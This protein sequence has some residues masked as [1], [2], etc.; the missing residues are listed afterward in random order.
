MNIRSPSLEE[1]FEVL[2]QEQ[3]EIGKAV[4][5]YPISLLQRRFRL[6]YTP[7]VELMNELKKKGLVLAVNESAVQLNNE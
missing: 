4:I 7:A 3:Q 6:S 1:A 2:L 5:D